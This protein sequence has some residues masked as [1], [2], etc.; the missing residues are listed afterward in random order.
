MNPLGTIRLILCSA[1]PRRRELLQGLGLEVELTAVDIDETPLAGTPSELAAEQI[2]LRKAEAWQGSL[3]PDQ[4]LLTADTVVVSGQYDLR[5]TC[6][7][8]RCKAYARTPFW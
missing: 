8:S 7:C 1:S 6:R 3:A 2:A 5:E 4:I